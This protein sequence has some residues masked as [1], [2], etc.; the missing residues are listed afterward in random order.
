MAIYTPVSISG[1]NSNPPED[2][3]TQVASNEVAWSKH[4]TKLGDPLKTLS[5]TIDTNV[6]T[7]F[8]KVAVNGTTALTVTTTLTAT[9]HGKVIETTGAITLDLTAAATLGDGWHIWLV[10]TDT[11]TVTIDPNGAELINGSATFSADQQHKTYLLACNGTGFTITN[12]EASTSILTAYPIGSIFMSVVATN[13]NTF[14]GGTW[15][16]IGAGKMLVGID[17]GDSDFD[18]VEETG[19]SK[20]HTLTTSQMP[21]HTHLEDRVERGGSSPGQDLGN[22]AVGNDLETFTV[23]SGS[24]GGGSA[25]PI[26]QPYLVVHMFKRTA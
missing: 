13:P 24:T 8:G 10:I 6:T 23:D 3:G 4:K 16:A 26:V 9:Q 25:H 11:S 21:A 14:F 5:E 2:D 20:T 18:V 19:G 12:H 7:A 17:T 22:L 1:Y 15:V